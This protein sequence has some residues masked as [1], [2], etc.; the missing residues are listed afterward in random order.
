MRTILNIN[1]AVYEP[2]ADLVTYRALPT[3][4]IQHID[5][6]LFLNHH[7]PQVYP[8]HNQGLPFGPHPHRGFETVT[9]VIDG[10]IYHKDSGG[11]EGIILPGGIQ[12]MTAGQGL[13]HSEVSSKEFMEKGGRLEILQLWVN[14]PSRH[15]MATPSYLDLQKEQIPMVKES[16]GDA[17]VHVVSGMWHGTLGAH[18]S[19]GDIHLSLLEMK[20]GSIISTSVDKPRNVFFYVIRGKVQV[21]DNDVNEMQLAEFDHDDDIIEIEAVDDAIVLFGHA[22][23]F[24]EPIVSH[25]PFVMNSQEE[26]MQAFADYRAGKMGVWKY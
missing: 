20:A 12:W 8:P 25:G 23:P 19:I 24:N 26:I 9:F 17:L 10:D 22:L 7:G 11:N 2:I 21:N 6:F 14:L 13:I 3:A 15:K 18:Q 5:P 16:S 4:S 1:D